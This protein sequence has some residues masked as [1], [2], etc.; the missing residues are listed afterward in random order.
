M[1]HKVAVY[2]TLRE[3]FGNNVLLQNSQKL[4]Q[5]LLPPNLTMY[6]HGGLPFV[7]NDGDTSNQV[8]VDVYE[9]DDSTLARLDRLEGHPSWYKREQVETDAFGMAWTYLNDEVSGL[10]VVE[11]GDWAEYTRTNRPTYRWS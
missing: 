11:S 6:T 8:L 9:V 10:D 2:G 3:G 1:S 5:A 4:G 7:H